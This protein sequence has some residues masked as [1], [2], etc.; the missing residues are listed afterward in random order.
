MS[1]QRDDRCEAII[2]RLGAE[3]IATADRC[4]SWDEISYIG[5]HEP[6]CDSILHPMCCCDF[7]PE[8]FGGDGWR[9][10]PAFT[11]E[12]FEAVTDRDLIDTLVGALTATD[13]NDHE[14]LAAFFTVMEIAK[15]E[16]MRRDAERRR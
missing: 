15:E 14:S 1:W 10:T 9:S 8:V 6:L 13:L 7:A 4:D 2:D 16:Q 5:W 11:A 12:T 3:E